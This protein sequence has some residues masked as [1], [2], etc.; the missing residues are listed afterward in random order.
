MEEIKSL[1]ENIE[2]I[3]IDDFTIKE[4]IKQI[5]KEFTDS[6]ENIEKGI[7]AENKCEKCNFTCADDVTMKKHMNTKH[8]SLHKDNDEHESKEERKK[9]SLDA[10]LEDSFKL[11]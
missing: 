5:E 11:R 3:K 9:E 8:G 2:M 7:E 6:E 10:D 4:K 1:K